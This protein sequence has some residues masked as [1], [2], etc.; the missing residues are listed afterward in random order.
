MPD[1]FSTDPSDTASGGSAERARS[2]RPDLYVKLQ[3]AIRDSGG[4]DKFVKEVRIATTTLQTILHTLA[5]ITESNNK[6]LRQP[7]TEDASPA[8]ARKWAEVFQKLENAMSKNQATRVP[9]EDLH[10]GLGVSSSIRKVDRELPKPSKA[11]VDLDPREPESFR[12]A[13]VIQNSKVIGAYEELLSHIIG[14]IWP[15]WSVEVLRE[16]EAGP[17]LQA[18]ED[19]N[20]PKA[21]HLGVGFVKNVSREVGGVAFL[22]LPGIRF[23]MSAVLVTSS[24]SRDVSTLG[25]DAI[26]DP[27]NGV[28]FHL[29]E[30]D[31]GYFLV[32]GQKRIRSDRMAG[33]TPFQGSGRAAATVARNLYARAKENPSRI[34]AFVSDEGTCSEV[35]GV[36]LSGDS[37]SSAVNDEDFKILSVEPLEHPTPATG[38]PPAFDISIAF[39]YD[40][41]IARLLK[42]AIASVYEHC[43]GEI[44]DIYFKMATSG[45]FGLHFDDSALREPHF[46]RF[47]QKLDSIPKGQLG[48]KGN[49]MQHSIFGYGPDTAKA[50]YDLA[51]EGDGNA[52]T[53]ESRWKVITDGVKPA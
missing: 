29:L 53:I 36:L 44:A 43:Y 3:R 35:R 38:Y 15:A 25:W 37:G 22:S 49:Q 9:L 8:Q 7:W 14:T 30:G 24:R 2:I 34:L 33:T 5:G 41:R 50:L 32:A 52:Y 40:E 16:M 4:R 1:D 6:P 12:F 19:R 23:S 46:R 11:L 26:F 10:D 51:T 18:L 13:P 17:L 21:P 48:F 27:K 45:A 39:W 31:C 20:A 42:N 47:L 28:K